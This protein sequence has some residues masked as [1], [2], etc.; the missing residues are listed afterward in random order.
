[1]DYRYNFIPVWLSV[2]TKPTRKDN[3]LELYLVVAVQMNRTK[4]TR[5][6][7]PL[8]RTYQ[9]IEKV[10]GTNHT[11]NDNPLEHYKLIQTSC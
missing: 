7:N 3:P 1:M 9:S 6:D 10:S 5:K 11:E 2:G 4:R 8:E